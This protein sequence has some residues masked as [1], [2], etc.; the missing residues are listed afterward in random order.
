MDW[1]FFS[2][3]KYVSHKA[4]TPLTTVCGQSLQERSTHIAVPQ[5]CE[6]IG[7]RSCHLTGVVLPTTIKLWQSL[8]LSPPPGPPPS[9]IFYLLSF[10]FYLP[11]LFCLVLRLG[12]KRAAQTAPRDNDSPSG[13]PP[14]KIQLRGSSCWNN[15]QNQGYLWRCC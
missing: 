2:L 3:G 12:I 4:S 15:R 13:V 11:F 7:Q 5:T 1:F 10:S 8:Q 9:S 6:G 14:K